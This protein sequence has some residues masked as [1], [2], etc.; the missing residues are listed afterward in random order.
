MKI[1]LQD[2]IKD[3]GICCFLSIIRYYGGNVSKEYLRDLTNTTKNG[4]S[5]YNLVEAAIKLG[6][7]SYAVNGDIEDIKKTDLPLIAHVNLTKNYKHFVVLYD[8]NVENNKVIIMDPSKGKKVISLSEFKLQ[9]TNNFIIMNPI[10]KIPNIEEKNIIKDTI[11]GYIKTEKKYVVFLSLLTFIY[12]LLNILS[13][14]HFKYLLEFAIN[15]EIDKNVLLI[16]IV[17]SIVY[18]F[19]ELSAYFRNILLLK[20]SQVFDYVITTKTYKQIILL[21]YLYYKNRTTGEVIS[22]IKDLNNIK[23]YLTSFITSF[24][25]DILCVVIFI[26]ILFN[27]NSNLAV[28]S[29]LLLLVLII[30][31]FLFKPLIKKNTNKYYRMEDKINS[32]LVES[33][34]SADA[35][36]GMHIEK[37]I[38]DKFSIKYKSYLSSIYNL[39]LILENNTLFKNIIHNIFITLILYYGVIYVINDILSLSKLIVYQSIFNFYITSFKNIINLINEYPKY[40]ASLERIEDI[41]TIKNEN[42]IGSSNFNNQK[43]KGVIKYTNL[44][45]KF[46]SKKIF[47]NINFEI[48]SKNKI[49][50]CGDS[51]S[52]KS[53]LV[54]MLM[55]YIEVPFKAISIG[56]IDINHY[57]LDI[58]RKEIMY[59]SSNEFLFNDTIRNNI[60]LNQDIDDKLLNKVVKLTHVDSIGDINNMVEENGFNYSSGEKQRIVLARSILKNSYIYIFDEAL[61]QI[62]IKL[63]R[64][65]LRNI[66]KYLKDKI[67]IVISH[68][69]E[70]KDLFDRIIRLDKGKIYE[71]KL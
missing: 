45:Y 55:R 21:P 26:I 64:D 35:I 1:V 22:R 65:I 4:V 13:A 27:I 49:F 9:S 69:N 5:A 3:C 33:L 23:S 48:F 36:K 6:F 53:T 42:F 11:I 61:S 56:S 25:T 40:K 38:V 51:G 29:V 7:N 8:V 20:Y 71:E 19:K 50:L 28:I 67:V 62:D 46:T 70:N 16:S 17:I 43:L 12:F 47:N 14:F 60:T 63:E 58:L 32:Y 59:V 68:R 31:N 44:N 34:S 37:R 2:G 41:F 52:G 15:Y 39:F 24:T 30:I 10:K 57:H 66:M 18:L 54:K